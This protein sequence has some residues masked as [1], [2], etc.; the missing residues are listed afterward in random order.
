M[1]NIVTP[2]YHPAESLDIIKAQ[3][4]SAYGTSDI[5]LNELHVGTYSVYV[6]SVLIKQI[7]VS[8][9]KGLYHVYIEKTEPS[10]R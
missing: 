9:R 5:D 6:K 4:A 10:R 8:R 2:E 3:L 1:S 7:W